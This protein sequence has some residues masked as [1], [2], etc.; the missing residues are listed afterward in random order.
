MDSK[1][2][3]LQERAW[4]VGLDIRGPFL[5]DLYALFEDASGDLLADHLTKEQLEAEV[6]KHQGVPRLS[7]ARRRLGG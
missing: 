4:K 7:E 5:Q 1:T 6:T 2:R 3:K